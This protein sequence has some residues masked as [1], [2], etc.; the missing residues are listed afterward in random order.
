MRQIM[1]KINRTVGRIPVLG[2]PWTC[3]NKGFERAFRAPS[4]PLKLGCA[5]T[6][7][8]IV[9]LFLLGGSHSAL[10]QMTKAQVPTVFVKA[11]LAYQEGDY[12]KAIVGYEEILTN[13]FESGPI[14]YNL[15]NSYFRNNELG[16][17]ILNYERALR[18]MPRDSD[19]QFNHRYALKEARL[20][21]QTRSLSFF[22]KVIQRYI[23]F[24]TCEEMVLIMVGALLLSGFIFLLSLFGKWPRS[25]RLGI[26][27]PCVAIFIIFTIGFILKGQY[28]RNLAIILTSADAKFEP[29]SNA[30]THFSLREGAQV[31]FLKRQSDWIKIKR[32]DGKLGWVQEGAAEKI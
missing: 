28:E 10:A 6:A 17:A 11:G 4:K 22:Q 16:N 2:L 26:L 27:V 19:L 5:R 18:L 20:P 15:A 24:Y 1:N 23:Q 21:R 13:G 14:Y 32:Q 31:R 30:T 7:L 25:V 9:A 3:S 29:R 8:L 12:E